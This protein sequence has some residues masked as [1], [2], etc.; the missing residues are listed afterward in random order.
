M[1]EGD[2]IIYGLLWLSFGAA[3][4]ALASGAAKRVTG[5]LFGA[6]ER[7]A[8]NAIA[9]FHAGAVVAIGHL[10]L[11][12]DDAG[13]FDLPLFA[14]IALW[15]SFVLG[16]IILLAACRH[17]DS[18]RFTGLR[19]VASG[20]D[21]EPLHTGGLHRYV[22]HPFYS[23]AF[24]ILIGIADGP[25]GLATCVWAGLYLIIGTFFEERRLIDLYGEAYRS[26]R[27]AVPAFIPWK[28]RA[29]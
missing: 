28:G 9:V 27:A 8:Y 12:G 4:S 14:A 1:S 13:S 7:L 22:R 20:D 3:H 25:F 19:A 11:G 26:Y 10:W 6:R 18:G 5:R 21:P 24:L 23:G 17:Y 15:V 29:I 2:H 16:W